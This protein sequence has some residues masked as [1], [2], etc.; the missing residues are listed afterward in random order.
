MYC[1]KN[2]SLSLV[3]VPIFDVRRKPKKPELARRLFPTPARKA[4][5]T[6]SGGEFETLTEGSFINKVLFIKVKWLRKRYIDI[7]I[8]NI[9]CR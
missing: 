5:N 8:L 7:Y 3:L 2:T 4:D 6:K 1:V 9:L